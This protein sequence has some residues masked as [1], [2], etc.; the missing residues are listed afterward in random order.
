MIQYPRLDRHPQIRSVQY[1]LGPVWSGPR[2]REIM[3]EEKGEEIYVSPL[4]REEKGGD[5]FH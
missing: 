2:S 4:L 3:R 5:E 1:R